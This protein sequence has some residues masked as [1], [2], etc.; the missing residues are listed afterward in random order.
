MLRNKHARRSRRRDGGILMARLVGK[1]PATRRFGRQSKEDDF[2]SAQVDGFLIEP[3][4]EGAVRVRNLIHRGAMRP[5][6]KVPSLKLQ[7]MVQCESLLE[8]DLA[9]LLD[10]SPHVS[11]FAEQPV[12]FR[13]V[14]DGEKRW[15]VPDFM[16]EH[17]GQKTYIEVKFEKDVDDSVRARTLLLQKILR[18]EGAAYRL[19][20]E[21]DIWKPSLV[22]N[23][24]QILRRACHALGDEELMSSYERL[25]I[26]SG[27]TLQDWSWDQSAASDAIALAK[28]LLKG[29]AYVDM[30]HPLTKDASVRLANEEEAGSWPMAHSE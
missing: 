1:T 23:A 30:A 27:M 17:A 9:L 15:H 18:E 14:L 29:K 2:L 26:S 28:L 8:V 20:T 13:F 3:P 21:A 4:S 7:R 6:F 16:V 24:R 22:A 19:C 12:T 10:A 11:G 25:R 5:V